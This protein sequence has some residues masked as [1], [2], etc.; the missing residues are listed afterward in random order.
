MKTVLKLLFILLV[1]VIVLLVTGIFLPANQKLVLTKQIPV[2]SSIVYD[3]L[4]NFKNWHNWSPWQSTDTAMKV[5][6]G[7]LYK[8]KQGIMSWES[9]IYG[10]CNLT[11]THA[12]M[13]E[14]MAVN[15]DFGVPGKTTG[16]WYI[17]PNDAGCNAIVTFNINDLSFFER[18]LALL[19]KERLYGILELGLQNLYATSVDLKYSRTSEISQIDMPTI[20][21]V[22]MI[23]SVRIEDVNRRLSRMESY[24]DRFFE[25]RGLRPAGQAFK[26]KDEPLNDTLI[27]IGVGYP[28]QERTWVWRTLKYL[29]LPEGKALTQIHYGKPENI[30][31]AHKE[32]SSFIVEKGLSKIGN[33]W[34]VHLYKNDTSLKDSSLFQIQVFYSIK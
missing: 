34:E 28:M 22:L 21:S 18:Y 26:W 4:Y 10:N 31:K 32:I 30:N 23:D 15:F 8:G 29:E 17:E 6:Y 27:K 3:Q 5:N 12:V 16:L 33:P 2:S 19:Q 14:S 11:I 25:L 1:L 20:P 7:E 9:T 24:L 13:P